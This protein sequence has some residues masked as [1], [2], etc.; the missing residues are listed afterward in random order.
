MLV[1]SGI[2]ITRDRLLK[3]RPS[4]ECC[5]CGLKPDQYSGKHMWILYN[6]VIYCPDCAEGE[7]WAVEDQ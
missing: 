3:L 7:G 1:E 2:Y 5:D 4:A 6:D